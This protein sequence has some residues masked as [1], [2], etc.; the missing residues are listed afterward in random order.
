MDEITAAI[1]GAWQKFAERIRAAGELITGPDFPGDPR[2]RAEGYRY[3]M[4]LAAQAHYLFVEFGDTVRPTLFPR[5]GDVFAYGAT[6][7]DNNNSRCM[8]DPGGVYRVTGD[9]GGVSDLIASVYEG[10]F[11]FGKPGVLAEV[12]LD[13]LHVGDDGVLELFLGGPERPENWMPLPPDAS[14]FGVRQFIVDWERDPIATLHIERIDAVD[15]VGNL[16]PASL[17]VALDKAASW[18]EANVKV[19]NMYSTQAAAHAPVNGFNLPSYAEGGS[20]S[21]VHGP[22]LWRLGP[23]EAL[24]IELDPAGAGYWSLQNYVLHWMQPLDFVNRVTSLNAAQARADADGKVRVVLAHRDPGVQNWLDTSGLPEGLC[25]GRWIGPTAQPE[26]HATLVD[27]ESVRASL[28]AA[29]PGFGA[30]DRDMQIAARRRGAA[31]R[32][33]R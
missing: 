24:V 31:R 6:N 30:A 20:E 11:V 3:V 9:V 4:R 27:V 21:M 5:G 33:R 8:V 7:V 18:L 15:P 12:K 19:W 2:L 14:Y 17:A 23:D 16:T 26:I 28:P 25:S 13:E 10:E 32:F 29:T 1:D 22:C